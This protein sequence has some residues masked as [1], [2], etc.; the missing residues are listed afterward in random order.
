MAERNNGRIKTGQHLSKATEFKKGQHW[1]K[2]KPYWNREW[3]YNEYVNKS[4]SSTDIAKDFGVT[5]GAIIFW[6]NKL[7]IPCRTISET[8]KVKKWGIKGNKNGMYGRKGKSNPHWKG[9]C[10][11]ERQAF[12]C[13]HEWATVVEQV[14]KRDNYS[15][16]KCGI[17]KH[18]LHIHHVI[19]FA[20]K[21]HRLDLD[22]LVLL[23]P[24]CHRFV[25][26]KKNI[27][28]EFI[29]GHI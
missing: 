1:R 14:W 27:E 25:H 16:R 13:S 26:S 18:G 6:L 4:R 8:R 10:T 21:A 5:D 29:N 24:K 19:S 9:G 17:S 28:G 12:Y 20:D 23:C 7:K 2:E 3:L 15:C 11:P 22:N